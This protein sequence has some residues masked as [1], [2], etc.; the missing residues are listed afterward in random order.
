M[1]LGRKCI[2]L[3]SHVMAREIVRI[4]EV[5]HGR[6]TSHRI[7]NANFC[8]VRRANLLTQIKQN[9]PIDHWLLEEDSRETNRFF[10]VSKGF[11][12]LNFATSKT[13]WSH[14]IR[15]AQHL[16]SNVFLHQPL[17]W[18]FHLQT[19]QN[20]KTFPSALDSGC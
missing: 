15:P 10:Q 13:V 7:M 16:L 12:F 4:S 18:F 19:V 5:T 17:N 6:S 20:V 11:W 14:Y 2:F 9:K 1:S 3:P 8:S